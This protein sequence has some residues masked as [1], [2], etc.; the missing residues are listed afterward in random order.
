MFPKREMRY[1][2]LGKEHNSRN[3]MGVHYV[4]LFPVDRA[5]VGVIY[6][7]GTKKSPLTIGNPGNVRNT[8]LCSPAAKTL[9]PAF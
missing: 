2:Y 3:G 6:K 4:V 9:S 7:H 1:F 5:T 8:P